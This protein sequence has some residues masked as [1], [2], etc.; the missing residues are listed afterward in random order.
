MVIAS[1]VHPVTRKRLGAE[2]AAAISM[3]FVNS[4]ENWPKV[5]PKTL[6]VKVTGH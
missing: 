3:F 1:S 2:A 4:T 5:T 6:K